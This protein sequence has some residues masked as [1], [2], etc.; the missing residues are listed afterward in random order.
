MTG[1]THV[2]D[3]LITEQPDVIT[4]MINRPT[5][6]N[7]INEDV[8]DGL[9]AA[10]N[11]AVSRTAKVLV[12]RGAEGCFCSGADLTLLL[13]LRRR[14][15]ALSRF[16]TRLGDLLTAWENAPLATIAVVEGYAVAGGCELL[17][18]CDL[19]IASSTAKIGDRHVENALVPA[20]GGS[21]RLTRALSKA[22]AHY[23]LLTGDLLSAQAAAEW[24]LVSHVAPP[25]HLH[26]HLGRIIDRLV[27][28]SPDALAAIKDMMRYVSE[29]PLEVSLRL[30]REI[31]LA[32]SATPDVEQGLHKFHARKTSRPGI[33]GSTGGLHRP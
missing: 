21:V 19:A 27:T 8:I 29:H 4:A 15:P 13:R 17:L 1:E 5:V 3:V 11:L 25:S 23:L 6:R 26:E 16:M 10:L 18:A 12:V 30:E 31:F 22:R 28:R 9:W 14:P 20:A 24:G 2:G 32:H 33:S 7:A